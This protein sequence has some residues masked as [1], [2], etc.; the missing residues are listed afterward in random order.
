MQSEEGGLL[1]LLYK[2]RD[3]V[4]DDEAHCHFHYSKAKNAHPIPRGDGCGKGVMIG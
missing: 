3:A 1:L 4:I 2:A